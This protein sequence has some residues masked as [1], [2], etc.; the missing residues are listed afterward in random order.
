MMDI[1]TAGGHGGHGGHDHVIDTG[2]VGECATYEMLVR[3]F[4]CVIFY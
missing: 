2:V 1:S 3:K 4:F